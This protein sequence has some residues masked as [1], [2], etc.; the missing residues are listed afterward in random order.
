MRME[1]FMEINKI[2]IDDW[3]DWRNPATFVE[4]ASTENADDIAKKFDKYIPTRN[5]VRT[6]M[7]VDAYRLEPFKSKFTQDDIRYNWVTMRIGALPL[8]VFTSMAA[9]ILLIACFNLT[10]T[11][12]AMTARR[13]KEVGIRKA[14]GAARA[15]IV[16]QFLLE[17]I[18]TITM[19]LVV[20]LLMAQVI[21]PAFVNMWKLPYNLK[22]LSGLNLFITL[23]MLVFLTVIAGWNIPCTFQQQVQANSL[24]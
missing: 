24:A 21:V 6:D 17:T 9:L 23:I 2:K 5:K 4:L 22:D 15:Q 11:S 7:V 16:S 20:G 3:S 13:L 19:A 12:I 14:I 18:I 10:N 1:N 8:V